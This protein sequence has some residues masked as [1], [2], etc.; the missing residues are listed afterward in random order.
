MPRLTK[1]ILI[2]L[3]LAALAGLVWVGQVRQPD[4]YLDEIRRTGVLR[5][6]IDPTYPPFASVQEG[7]IAGYEA[8]LAE[9]IARDLG[10][11]AEFVPL[12]LD[13]LYDALEAER[14][15]ILISSLPFVYERQQEVRYSVPY[16]D[17]GQVIVVREGSRTPASASGLAGRR[18]GVELGSAA[19]TEVRRL[20]REGVREIDLQ[21][22]DTP[23]EALAALAQGE[24]DAAVTDVPAAHSYMRD[25]PGKVALVS[26]QLTSEPYVAAVPAGAQTLAQQ[27]DTTLARLR[28]SGELAEMMGFPS[29]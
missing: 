17:A 19:D 27:V 5:V 8:R 1:D 26:P 24:L 3:T 14:V 11:R 9:E 20:G 13:G 2:L 29:R 22:F 4:L 10:V 16:Y 25:N 21:T 6:G 18:V 7:R 28:A 12:A 23:A 15:D